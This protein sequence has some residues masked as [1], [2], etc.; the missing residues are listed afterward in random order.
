VPAQFVEDGQIVLNISPSAVH[1]LVMGNDWIQFS[2]RF[3]GNAHQ[4]EI[5]SEAVIGIFSRENHQGMVFP[6]AES[7]EAPAD[8]PA[9]AAGPRPG[10]KGTIPG[11]R[12][13]TG[14]TQGSG[15][16]PGKGPGKG[17]SGPKLKV[18]K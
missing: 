6:P 15:K 17:G 3:G 16:G 11:P 14:I 5:P 2:A 4:L 7:A 13:V 12:P 10:P 9:T 1:G 18:I 8:A